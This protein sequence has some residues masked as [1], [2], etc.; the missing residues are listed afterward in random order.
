MSEWSIPPIGTTDYPFVG[1][2][3]GNGYTVSDCLT[4]NDFTDFGTKHPGAVTSDNFD[5]SAVKIVG[6][7]GVVG[8]LADDLYAGTYDSSVNTISNLDLTDITVKTASADTLIGIAAGYVD[9]SI[10]GVTI[11]GDATIDV[12]GQTS[13]AFDSTL[14][15]NL[16]DYGLVGYATADCITEASDVSEYSQGISAQYTNASWAGGSG[17]GGSLKVDEILLRMYK[18]GTLHGTSSSGSYTYSDTYESL[19]V[20]NN[21]G[22]TLVDP[23]TKKVTYQ[24]GNGTVLPFTLEN[25]ATSDDTSSTEY[26]THSENNTGY[27]I[28]SNSDTVYKSGHG[29]VSSV[30]KIASINQSYFSASYSSSYGDGSSVEILTPV[31]PSATFSTTS[32]SAFCVVEDGYNTV[33]GGSRSDTGTATLSSYSS[34]SLTDLGFADTKKY[35]KARDYLNTTF[36]EDTYISGMRFDSIC[37]S[38]TDTLTVDSSFTTQIYDTNLTDATNGYEFPYSCVDFNLKESGYIDFFAGATT[39]SGGSIKCFFS[40][41]SIQRDANNSITAVTEINSIYENTNEATMEEYPYIYYSDTS[42]TTIIEDGYTS[43]TVTQGD[44]VYDMRYVNYSSSSTYF[45][46]NAIFF[47]EIPVNKGEYALSGPTSKPTGGYLIY[48]D[49]GAN[50]VQQDVVEA[51]AVTTNKTSVD[52]AYPNG[53]DFATTDL[54]GTSGGETLGIIIASDISGTVAFTVSGTTITYA[55]DVSTEYAFAVKEA[56]TATGQDPPTNSIVEAETITRTTIV[57]IVTVESVEWDIA[58]TQDVST[59]DGT[60]GEK[61]YDYIL[62][63]GVADTE[64]NI[65]D[66]LSNN[67]VSIESMLAETIIVLTRTAGTTEFETTAEF[68]STDNTIVALTSEL[69]DATVSAGSKANGYTFTLNSASI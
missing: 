69:G 6:F 47:Y 34:K 50:G 7:F 46:Q 8:E 37:A 43:S 1:C 48:L 65:P 27:V 68:D 32:T 39:N 45:L 11:G 16:S 19:Y 36:T 10:S 20:G 61:T 14:T 13:T 57:H 44:K 52:Y 12:S 25:D 59:S 62:N 15:T 58:Y 56:T 5:S 21:Q 9:A 60:L 63:A 33:S 42:G 64:A 31:D 4:S 2:F 49:I 17:F 41:Y 3:N 22:A 35:A 40:L 26:V 23:Q 28:G 30:L 24:C 51:Y 38:A 53:V 18:L 29:S 54:E 66:S 55:S 67:L